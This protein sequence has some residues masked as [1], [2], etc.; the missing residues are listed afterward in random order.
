MQV[1][2][3]A[4]RPISA[5]RYTYGDNPITAWLGPGKGTG[6]TTGNGYRSYLRT[7]QHADYPSGSGCALPDLTQL[8]NH[9]ASVTV[10]W[11]SCMSPMVFRGVCSPT[12]S[13]GGRWWTA[14]GVGQGHACLQLSHSAMCQAIARRGARHCRTSLGGDDFG[15]SIAY[16]AG[17]RPWSAPGKHWRECVRWL[18]NLGWKDV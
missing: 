10:H 8:T 3:D 15:F 12:A 9:G 6:A 1:K 16:K 13:F 18:H 11:L 7:M 14:V 17:M 5:I 4:I 2:F